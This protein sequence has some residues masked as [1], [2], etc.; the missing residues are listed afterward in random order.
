[1]K[2]NRL[3]N[4]NAMSDA[5][6]E[7]RVT[8]I[9]FSVYS[10]VIFALICISILLMGLTNYATTLIFYV[11]IISMVVFTPAWLGLAYIANKK[12]DG[13]DFWY[14]FISLNITITIILCV[15]SMISGIIASFF[16]YPPSALTK[17]P[18]LLEFGWFDVGLIN[19]FSII[20]LYLTY[21]Y[22]RLVSHKR[23]TNS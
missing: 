11:N 14:R 3:I 20:G 15:I 12:G 7:K 8:K 10:V 13:K 5:L 2:I 19:L 21:K 22:M 4:L 16:I 9:E 18:E 23:D 1:M 6:R 17:A